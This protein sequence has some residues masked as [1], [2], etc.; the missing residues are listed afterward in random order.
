MAVSQQLGVQFRKIAGQRYRNP[1]VAAEVAHFTFHPALLVAFAGRAE[2]S[3]ILPVRTEGDEA[4]RQLALVAAQDLLH[5]A[6]Q[7]IVAKPAENAAEVMER[8]LVRFQKRLLRDPLAIQVGIGFIPID[9]GFDAPVVALRHKGLAPSQPQRLFAL[10]HILPHR[11]LGSRASGYLLSNA[12][13]Y[14]LRRVALLVRS[15]AIGFQNRVDELRCRSHLHMWPLRLLP[16]R[17]YRASNRVPHQSPVH[18]QL[19]RH[20]LDRAYPKL[21]FPTNLLE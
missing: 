7:I 4:S 10:R 13:P 5:R 16:P 3:L 1:V 18:P 12:L 2:L 21:I 20:A 14:P 17:R 11:A 8:Q 19:P 6:R 15:L 9:L